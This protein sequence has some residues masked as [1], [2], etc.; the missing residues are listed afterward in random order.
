MFRLMAK[1]ESHKRIHNLFP[2]LT[3]E[4]LDEADQRLRAY[5]ALALRVF[6][7]IEADPEKYAEFKRQLEEGKGE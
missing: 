1:A 4:E 2:D 6:Q 7:K 3:P 5:A